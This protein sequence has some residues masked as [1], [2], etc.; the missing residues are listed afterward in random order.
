MIKPRETERSQH[1]MIYQVRATSVLQ[2]DHLHVY[3]NK[4][5]ECNYSLSRRL[6]RYIPF[7]LKIPYIMYSGLNQKN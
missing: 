4:I 1:D 3:W 7:S 2:I 5:S 6:G